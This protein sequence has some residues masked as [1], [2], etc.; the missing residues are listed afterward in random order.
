MSTLAV[1]PQPSPFAPC[2]R[3]LLIIAA[4]ALIVRVLIV[5]AAAR[6][7]HQPVGE[8]STWGDAPSYIAQAQA[9]RGDTS[10]LTDFDRRTFPGYSVFIAVV[11]KVGIPLVPA[12][13]AI[14]WICAAI[15]AAAAAVLF[16]D[17]RIGYAMA[18][19]TP[20]YLSYS[21]MPMSE[22]SLLAF[23]M[24]GML[25]GGCG[26]LPAVFFGALLIGFSGVIRPMSCFGAAGY[27]TYEFFRGRRLHAIVAAVGAGAVVAASVI[28]MHLWTGDALHGVHVYVSDPKAYNGQLL[29]WPFHSLIAT[30]F[31]VD[32]PYLKRAKILYVWIHVIV[33]LSGCA[34]V[35]GRVL[36]AKREDR[37]PHALDVLSIPWLVGNTLFVLCVGD[38]WGFF[39]FARFI[40]PAL[41]ALFWAYRNYLPSRWWAWVLIAL[42]SM[43]L[44]VDSVKRMN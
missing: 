19:L 8:F 29:T 6:V 36:R 21:S 33:T 30:P 28:L 18:V 9:M 41:P 39:A 2:R 42:P 40:V 24:V 32:L 44:A 23:L 1:E 16:G 26:S 13:M 20:H 17:R 27:I 12:A 10:H 43:A 4:V 15:A 31:R 38:K 22:S 3:D 37:P 7:M 35:V 25:V 14:P 11:S 34:I 5:L